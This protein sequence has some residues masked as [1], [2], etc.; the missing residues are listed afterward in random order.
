MRS[1]IW[2][3]GAL[4][5]C[6]VA[7]AQRD[8][9]AKQ[10]R[11]KPGGGGA[12]FH[13]GQPRLEHPRIRRSGRSGGWRSSREGIDDPLDRVQMTWDRDNTIDPLLWPGV[14]QYL[15]HRRA[16]TSVK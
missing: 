15:Q 11:R 10:S 8:A 9:D 2:I 6:S 1:I 4:T 12:G 7:P 16:W 3:A 5:A 13:E 14:F